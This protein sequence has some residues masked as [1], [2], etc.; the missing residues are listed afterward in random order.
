MHS[1]FTLREC[2]VFVGLS[3]G[4]LGLLTPFINLLRE[5]SRQIQCANNLRQI[6]F[7]VQNYEG[8]YKRFPSNGVSTA[9]RKTVYFRWWAFNRPNAPNFG[10][11]KMATQCQFR[12][13]Y[14]RRGDCS[15]EQDSCLWSNIDSYWS[16]K[17]V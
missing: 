13:K 1:Q 17:V 14:H 11:G 12:P 15:S 3:A 4:L 9:F 5:E 2:V 7:A 16:Y 10:A 6:A 8:T